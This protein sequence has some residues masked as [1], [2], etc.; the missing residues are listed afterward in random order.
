MTE[1]FT[2]GPPALWSQW[3]TRDGISVPEGSGPKIAQDTLRGPSPGWWW[4]CL[5]CGH[6][7]QEM[8]ALDDK[9]S[10]WLPHS[11]EAARI[12]TE[13]TFQ[14]WQKSLFRSRNTSVLRGRGY[15]Q[16]ILWSQMAFTAVN[17]VSS[18][19]IPLWKKTFSYG[20]RTSSF[21]LIKPLRLSWGETIKFA[22]QKKHKCGITR[23][24][25]FF[26]TPNIAPISR[27]VNW[28]I[29]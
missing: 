4:T 27:N 22:E 14:P 29:T 9:E 17:T 2:T 18:P 6:T 8:S 11:S 1:V 3:P 10:K 21:S 12:S 25:D 23:Q 19:S 16:W 24:R 7:R 26:L 28:K 5:R 20:H 13:L 15:E